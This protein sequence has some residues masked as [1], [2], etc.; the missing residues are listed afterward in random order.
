MLGTLDE[1]VPVDTARRLTAGIP[2]SRLTY[3]WGAAHVPEYD[4]PDRLTRLI[5]AFMEHGEG[6]LVRRPA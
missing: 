3:I 6:Y 1:I 4:Q 2:Q 5:G